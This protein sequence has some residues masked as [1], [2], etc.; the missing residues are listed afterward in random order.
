[1]KA[2]SL[3]SSLNGSSNCGKQVKRNLRLHI[4]SDSPLY[5]LALHVGYFFDI[6]PILLSTRNVAGSYLP[7]SGIHL[8]GTLVLT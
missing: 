4:I 3:K 7:A 8:S 5:F 6:V 2:S 1:M